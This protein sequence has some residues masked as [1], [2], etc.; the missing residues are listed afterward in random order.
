[1][2]EGIYLFCSRKPSENTRVPQNKMS[3]IGVHIKPAVYFYSVNIG[4]NE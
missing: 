1:M 4:T 3:Q 2:K